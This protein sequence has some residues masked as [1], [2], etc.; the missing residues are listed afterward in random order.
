[1]QTQILE[2]FALQI[3]N[4]GFEIDLQKYVHLKNPFLEICKDVQNQPMHVLNTTAKNRFSYNHPTHG[5]RSFQLLNDVAEGF[6]G[7]IY[8]SK[9][10]NNLEELYIKQSM[11]PLFKEVLL[12]ILAYCVLDVYK[13]SWVV[14]KINDVFTSK[15][16]GN[17]FTM[18]P[19]KD[20]TIYKIYLETNY[21]PSP[22]M[23]NDIMIFEVVGQLALYNYILEQEIGL[24]HRDLRTPNILMICPNE[25]QKTITHV[26]DGVCITIHPKNHALMVDFGN[27]C[28]PQTEKKVYTPSDQ[29][30]VDSTPKAGRDLFQ[31]LAYL[32]NQK[33][34]RD[35]L[36]ETGHKLFHSLLQGST[37]NWADFLLQNKYN[38]KENFDVIYMMTFGFKFYSAQCSPLSIFQK[39]SQAYPQ[40]ITYTT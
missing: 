1:M 30:S 29:Y 32:Y 31:M 39:I 22:C 23:E 3:Q 10:E 15:E 19:K 27:S 16:F 17:M 37:R 12:Q 13:F 14:P 6:Y 24:N 2:L 26:V 36:T 33:M 4:L 28:I 40:I 7:T 20:T 38:E 34:I 9:W 35:G 25:T 21:K 11:Y 8:S 5:I 18:I